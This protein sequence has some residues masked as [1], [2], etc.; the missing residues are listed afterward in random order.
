MPENPNVLP[1]GAIAAASSAM[2][3]RRCEATDAMQRLRQ[4]VPMPRVSNLK[5]HFRRPEGMERLGV[6]LCGAE[7][8]N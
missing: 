7:L 2:A 5:E 1:V 8:S 3:G 4:I 6:G